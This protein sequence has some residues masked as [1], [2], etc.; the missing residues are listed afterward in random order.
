M[1]RAATVKMS[2]F[3]L[4]PLILALGLLLVSSCTP[5]SQQHYD[6]GKWYYGKGLINEAILEFKAAT[7]EDPDNYQAH[8]SLAIAY[9]KKGWYDYALKEA[10]LSFELHPSDDNYRLIQIVR[11]KKV[12]EPAFESGLIDTLK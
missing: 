4:S 7:Q 8:H 9:T 5:K 3:F 1:K 12:L 2:V 6:L 10:E 11:D